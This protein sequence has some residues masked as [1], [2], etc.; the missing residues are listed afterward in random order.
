MAK[1]FMFRGK[2]LE[3]LKQMSIE[4]FARLL[5]S[6]E[7]RTLKKGLQENQKMLLEEIKNNPDKFHKTHIRDMII[8]PQMVGA[9]IGVFNGK[10]WVSI[11]ITPEMIGRRIGEFS[12][13]IKRVKH[14]APGIGATRGSKFYAAKPT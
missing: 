4:E 8:L 13:P 9:K 1:V 10:E 7:R 11:Y 12:I 2:T 6:K 14:S 3:E 5:T